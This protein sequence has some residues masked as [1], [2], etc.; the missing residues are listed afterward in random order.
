M[1][2]S[3]VGHPIEEEVFALDP[4]MQ[5]GKYFELWEGTKSTTAARLGI[6][7]TP[8]ADELEAMKALG[9]GFMDSVR[10]HFGRIRVHSWLRVPELNAAIPDSSDT[11]AHVWG[12]ACDFSPYAKGVTL[13]E[14]VEWLAASDLPF[15]QVI[16][17]Y[18]AWIHLGIARKGRDPRRQVLMKFKGSAYLSFD[19]E[20]PRV[21]A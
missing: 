3:D 16:Y 10:E 13:K 6:D 12:G 8:D 9:Y 2:R 15:D 14:I 7:N 1:V 21:A 5:L 4:H 11:S 17:E 19:P 20:D 18:G